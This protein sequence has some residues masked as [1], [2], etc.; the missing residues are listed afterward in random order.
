MRRRRR[1][2]H[3]HCRHPQSRRRHP[4]TLATAPSPPPP[5][6]LTHLTLWACSSSPFPPSIKPHSQAL[7][8]SHSISDSAHAATSALP[9]SSSNHNGNITRYP[10]S[11]TCHRTHNTNCSRRHTTCS[12]R[13]RACRRH[14]DPFRK[15]RCRRSRHNRSRNGTRLRTRTRSGHANPR[16]APVARSTAR[17]PAP[18]TR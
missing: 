6:T 14:H 15:L 13:S 12:I 18:P 11:S 3:H 1:Q 9:R 17:T 2:R 8:P 16:S 7:L 5:I 10:C 4:S